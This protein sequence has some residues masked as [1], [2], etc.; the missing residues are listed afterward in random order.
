[1]YAA[2]RKGKGRMEHAVVTDE[3]PPRLSDR[4]QTERRATARV[5]CNHGARV[6]EAGQVG[7]PEEFTTLRDLSAGGVGMSLGKPLPCDT[8]VVVEPLI[9]GART[10]LAR[11]VR[12]AEE[13]GSWVHGCVLSPR[14]S[15]DELAGWLQA[16]DGEAGPPADGGADPSFP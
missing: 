8:L 6:R 5:L 14:L 11:V 13:G 7:A 4:R 1:M 10:L 3:P 15:A 2:K 12:V 16:G 9:P